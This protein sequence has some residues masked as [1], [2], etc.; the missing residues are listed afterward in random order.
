V[1]AY[2][3]RG[4][5]VTLGASSRLSDEASF[6][7]VNVTTDAGG[8]EA[9]GLPAGEVEESAIMTV[10][11]RGFLDWKGLVPLRC[12]TATRV[13]LARGRTARGRVVAG[14]G[15]ASGLLVHLAGREDTLPW[16]REPLGTT[17]E[18]G[19]FVVEGLPDRDCMLS[20]E[21]PGSV[22]LDAI[23]VIVKVLR[24][25][26]GEVM[27]LGDIL[28]RERR[29]VRGVVLGVGSGRVMDC[30]V[31]ILSKAGVG[32][33]VRVGLGGEFTFA[34]IPDGTY[35]LLAVCGNRTLGRREAVD[36]NQD[37]GD[38]VIQAR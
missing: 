33:S 35:E 19:S 4:K 11:R 22:G 27:N 2:S 21:R 6:V 25:V 38:I 18:D 28:L 36:V 30:E 5:S 9:T 32:K 31:F 17:R 10:H 8:V 26:D 37:S 3:A 29:V 16:S 12:D 14:E 24:S 1:I 15:S 20:I 34:S 23:G 7:R 13:V